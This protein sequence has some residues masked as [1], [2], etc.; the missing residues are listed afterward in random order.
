MPDLKEPEFFAADLR[1]RFPPRIGGALPETLEEYLDL[2]RPAEPGQVLGEASV[3]YLRS[4][5]AAQQIAEVNPAA[6]IIAILREPSELLRSLHLQLIYDHIETVKD[7]RT[8]LSLED[9]RRQGEAI[10]RSS[11]Q[12]QLLLYSENVRYVDQLKRFHAVFPREQ[13]TVLLYDE[14]LGDND[15]ALHHI[16]RFLDVDD[17]VSVAPSKANPSTFLRSAFAEDLVHRVSVGRGPVERVVKGATKRILSTRT[18]RTLLDRAY[19]S[20]HAAPLPV[21]PDL[22][23]ELRVRFAPEVANLSD[24]LDRDVASAW[25]YEL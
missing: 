4:H 18:R 24:Y 23:A 25:G 20:L 13:V 11:H 5:V 8:A 3:F 12:P 7:F 10:P 1:R 22:M 21:D 2:F 15:R 6:R 19:R 14:F 9:Q 16:F 17:A